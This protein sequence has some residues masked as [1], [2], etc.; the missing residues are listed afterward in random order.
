MKMTRVKKYFWNIWVSF[1]Q[2]VN[3]LFGGD[4]D[5]TISSRVAKRRPGCVFCRLLCWFLDKIDKGHCD[6][7]IELDEG[8]NAAIK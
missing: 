2:F 7:S 1:D 4:P 5:E 3:T 8:D 6:K